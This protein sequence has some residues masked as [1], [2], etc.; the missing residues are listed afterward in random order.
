MRNILTI[1]GVALLFAVMGF[2]VGLHWNYGRFTISRVN[3]GAPI[4]LDRQT[5]QTWCPS[6]LKWLEAG[7]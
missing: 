3:D 1:I 7:R 6:N 2:I 5:G 4:L